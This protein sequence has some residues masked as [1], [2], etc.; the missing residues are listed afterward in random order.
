MEKN[1]ADYEYLRGLVEQ[2]DRKLKDEVQNRLG[3]DFENK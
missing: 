2:I 1:S 3:N